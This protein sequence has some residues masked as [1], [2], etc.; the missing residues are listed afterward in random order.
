MRAR[1]ECFVLAWACCGLCAGC[2]L[3]VQPKSNPTWCVPG[4]PPCAA[5]QV[6]AEVGR[7]YRCVAAKKSCAVDADC[8]GNRSGRRFCIDGI[9]VGCRTSADCT[10]A[11]G[12]R[13][14]FNHTCVPGCD[15]EGCCCPKGDRCL[16]G[17]CRSPQ[18][19]E[20]NN[21]DDDLDGQV[22]EDFDQDGDGVSSCAFVSPIPDCDDHTAEVEPGLAERCDGRDNNCDGNIDENN[23][24]PPGEVCDRGI[25]RCVEQRNPCLL[26]DDCGLELFCELETGLCQP[27]RVAFGEACIEDHQCEWGRCLSTGGLGPAGHRCTELCCNE[28][29]CPTRAWCADSGRG[30]KV[31]A[32]EDWYQASSVPCGRA[33]CP[34]CSNGQCRA[35]CCSDRDCDVGCQL[36][37]VRTPLGGEV[38]TAV[39]DVR[40]GGAGLYQ[41]SECGEVGSAFLT[42]CSSGFQWIIR[43]FLDIPVACLCTAPCC[44]DQDCRADGREPNGQCV[45]GSSGTA[46]CYAPS[47]LGPLTGT[48][49]FGE[50]CGRWS[51]CADG[52]CH[53]RGYCSRVCCPGSG[54]PA[55]ATCEPHSSGG[56]T[57]NCAPFVERGALFE[58][59]HESSQLVS[60][61]ARGTPQ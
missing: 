40:T 47:V 34:A 10:V 16:Q 35:Q 51:Q 45:V 12:G 6:C 9:C 44:S 5:G 3:I 58:G 17:R 22:D 42:Y 2:S 8:T 61:T 57:A 11:E 15:E 20:C 19:E 55:G 13:Y 52:V 29:D 18:R 37:V 26:D 30:I 49:G 32:P 56:E 24:C 14:C 28:A 21:L 53:P 43:A 4:G 36:A 41:E 50:P 27:R 7:E 60:S 33:Q 48:R 54:C 1:R 25:N 31:C 23:P 39:C 38:A 59:R 46:M